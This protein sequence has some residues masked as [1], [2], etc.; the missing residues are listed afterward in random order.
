MLFSQDHPTAAIEA[1]DT[2]AAAINVSAHGRDVAGLTEAMQHTVA[3][4]PREGE[5]GDAPVKALPC[6]CA[7]L[8][9][10]WQ[11]VQDP[12]R[13]CRGVWRPVRRRLWLV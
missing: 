9:R 6:K 11:A 2:P 10:S 8:Q 4:T 13:G 3:E 5:G 1:A 7:S 12:R